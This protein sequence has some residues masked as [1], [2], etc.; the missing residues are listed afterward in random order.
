MIDDK[1]QVVTGDPNAAGTAAAQDPHGRVGAYRLVSLLG[2]GGMGEVWLAERAD[3]AYSKRVAIKFISSFMGN[4]EAIEWFR[5]ERQALARLEHPNIARLLDGGETE[6]GRPF[7]VME[8]VDGIAIDAY[9]EGKA[10]E[11]I[12]ELFLQVCSAVDHAHRALIV[13][14]DIKPANVLVIAD[15]QSRLLDFGIAKEMDPVPDAAERTTTQAYTLHF[16]SPEQMEG[17]VITVASDIYSLGALLYRLLSGR[18]PHAGTTSALGQL[19]AI[20]TTQP[21]KPSQIVLD[22]AR[23]AGGERKRRAR[24]LHG[25]LDDI[26]L[27]CLRREPELRY[28]S[29]RELID[30]IERYRKHEPVLA[31]RGSAA[32]RASRYL[33]RH[34]LAIGAAAAVLVTLTGGLLATYWQ[35]QEAERQR[36]LAQKRFDL[37]RALVNEVM[38]DFQDQLQDVPGTIQARRRLVQQSRNYLERVAEDA[39]DEPGLLIDLSRAERRLGEIAGNPVAPNLGDTPAALR[40]YQRAVDQARRAVQL[41]PQDPEAQAALARALHSQ[42]TL[43]FWNDDLARAER[44]FTEELTILRAR[45]RGGMTPMLERE[46]SGATMGL[47]DVYF[48]SSKL[49]L[50]LKTYDRACS[51]LYKNRSGSFEARDAIAVCHTRR[52]DALAWLERYPEAEKH[53]ATALA[54]YRQMHAAQPQNLN[55]VHSILIVLNKQGEIKGW[56]GKQAESLA[57]YSESLAIAEP[58]YLKDTSDL[59]SARNLA[60]AYNKRGDAYVEGKRFAEAI[61]DYGK[62]REIIARLW[63]NDPGQ[64]E[65]ERDYAISNHRIGIALVDSGRAAEAVPYFD[66]E[67]AIMRRRW[68]KAPT[69]AWARRDLAVAIQDRI[70]APID[71]AGQLCAW[72]IEFRDLMGALKDMG[73]ANPT[74]LGELV[75]AEVAA[76]DCAPPG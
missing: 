73:A 50:A 60:L 55:V 61:A 34:W 20:H 71:D 63:K 45:A 58:M 75:K 13:H 36:A 35:A 27:K 17:G 68:Q 62:A 69:K 10:L 74:D 28:G 12:L 11:Q 4:R 41:R 25:D 22:D 32:Y 5:R 40:H 49:E 43:Y 37:S 2:K 56:M 14:R 31:R 19:Q 48:W 51:P 59:R 38:F 46:V 26:V 52:A 76:K 24:H 30:D 54:S 23:L 29:A 1:T 64:I 21:L 15:G 3:D 6:D 67:V 65:H 47:A 42:G 66:E 9:C 72:R 8:Y 33:R 18:V 70:E 16:A 53:I 44:L 39:Q 57:A 7:L